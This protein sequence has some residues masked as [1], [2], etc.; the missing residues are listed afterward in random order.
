MALTKQNT[1]DEGIRSRLN[2]G[3]ACYHVVQKLRS[4]YFQPENIVINVLL[5]DVLY[6][7][8]SLKFHTMGKT[9]TEYV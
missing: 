1:T 8:E 6:G 7:S 3:H 5:L 2:L 4:S 9:Q